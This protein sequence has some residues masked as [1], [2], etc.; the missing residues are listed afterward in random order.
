[1]KVFFQFLLS[2][3][4]YCGRHKLISI[5]F[6]EV[7]GH[8]LSEQKLAS[9]PVI[10]RMLQTLVE[11]AETA[12]V[13]GRALLFSHAI[14]VSFD[15]RCKVDTLFG[16]GRKI[17]DIECADTESFSDSYYFAAA[18]EHAQL[19]AITQICTDADSRFSLWITGRGVVLEAQLE[20]FSLV[21]NRLCQGSGHF[22]GKCWVIMPCQLRFEF[23][24]ERHGTDDFLSNSFDFSLP[25]REDRPV[26]LRNILIAVNAGLFEALAEALQVIGEATVLGRAN[27]Q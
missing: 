20:P 15:L 24:D 12:A 11:L 18:L 14:E 3:L 16:D 8:D 6:D 2:L 21:G 10:F 17:G 23:L 13:L 27:K 22:L 19:E 5:K 25:T 9:E 1:M 26:R 7:L 4:Q